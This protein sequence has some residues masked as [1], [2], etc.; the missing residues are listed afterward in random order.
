[1]TVA[2]ALG[3]FVVATKGAPP[4]SRA[5]AKRCVLDLM[6]AAIG[7]WRTAGATAAIRGAQLS[8]GA[9]PCAVWFSGLELTAAGAAFANSAMACQLDL[10]D[11]H[12]AAAGHPG[13][14]IIPAVLAT[15]EEL[16]STNRDIL[17]AIAI[18]YEVA[19]RISAARDLTQ[20][21]TT[22]SGLWCGPGA[23]AAA[24]W[25][26]RSS[27]SAI[28]H[29]IAICGTT[30]PSQIATPYTK[31]MGNHVKEGIPVATAAA[32]T[33]LNLAESGFTGPLD[34]YD[35][36]N[37]YERAALLGG[38]GETWH[39]ENIYFK[40]Y[41][42]CRWAHASVDALVALQAEHD[43][44]APAIEH[45]RVETFGRALT[46]NN[47]PAPRSIEAAQYSVP[48]CLGLAGVAGTGALLP[49]EE[50]SLARPDAVALA[51][52]VELAVDPAFDAMFSAAVP[53]RV[54]VSA[55][56]TRY[57]KTVIAPKG[58]PT[59]A[60]TDDDLVAKLETIVEGH[61][62][63]D[64]V[65]PVLN[66]VAALEADAPAAIIGLLRSTRLDTRQTLLAARL[67]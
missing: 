27:A 17:S 7:G 1:M 16:G 56:G 6:S 28:A 34:I 51:R 50:A 11:G 35:A 38:L 24:G 30:A 9:G 65:R 3:A 46:L 12:R 2:E 13:A 40:P 18:G 54:I 19:I 21:P 25:L 22:D 15:A 31:E 39:I 23:A 55:H 14:S 32:I 33:A 5:T 37:L 47:Q 42:A 66:A 10:D 43:L 57:E 67:A 29:A 53:A 8:W 52:K 61:A 48:F 4:S 45:I 58:E 44:P 62:T 36:E 20:I 26:R 63:E 41:S 59:N 49:L 64:L 60:M